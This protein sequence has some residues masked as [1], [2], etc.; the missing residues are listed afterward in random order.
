MIDVLGDKGGHV[1]GTALDAIP[2]LFAYPIVEGAARNA[3][4][5]GDLC[6]G[7]IGLKVQS[8]GLGLL[9][10]I[11]RKLILGRQS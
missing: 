11:H 6:L 9:Q 3:E 4:H 8:F 7:E 1:G 10:I 2:V 5:F